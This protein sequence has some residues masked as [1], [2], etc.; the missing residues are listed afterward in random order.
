LK[1]SLFIPSIFSIELFFILFVL[2]FQDD[3]GWSTVGI[4]SASDT[5]QGTA[6]GGTG[7]AAGNQQKGGQRQETNAGN[8]TTNKSKVEASGGGEAGGVQGGQQ[9]KKKKRM[10]KIDS[11]ILGFTVHADPERLNMGEIDTGLV[12]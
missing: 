8:G 11:S 10:Q 6:G 2:F 4:N 12:K 1:S 5:K 3:S 7:A 9:Q